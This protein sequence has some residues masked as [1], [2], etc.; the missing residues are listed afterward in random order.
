[1]RLLRGTNKATCPKTGVV[2]TIGNFDG[3]HLGHQA[4]LQ[5]LNVKAKALNL[6]SMLIVFE[7]QPHEFFQQSTPLPRLTNFREKWRILEKLN[8]DY[9]ACLR[10]DAK[11]S[12]LTAEQFAEDVL[13]EALSIQHLLVGEDF[14][15]GNERLGDVSLLQTIATGLNREVSVCADVLAEG[16][17]VSSTAIR[18]LL[19]TYQLKEA[20]SLL[21][22][23]YKMCGRVVHGQKLGRTIGVPTA[24]IAVKRKALPMTGVFCVKATRASGEVCAGIANLGTRP[25]VDGTTHHLEVHL[26]DFDDDLYGEHLEVSFL[27][28]LREE[29]KYPTFDALVAQIKTD[30]L[31]ARA[32]MPS[33]IS[34]IE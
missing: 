13:F 29:V 16:V 24:N 26:F 8:I 23:P 17:R 31:E 20:E 1:M 25:T 21:G 18:S 6:P 3:I 33:L 11:L 30:I 15:F 12:S 32:L 22:R 28:H 14:R 34:E 27:H 7:P 2:A 9:V 19:K 4:L 10:F 5:A